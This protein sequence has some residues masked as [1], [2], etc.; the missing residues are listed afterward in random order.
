MK[1]FSVWKNAKSQNAAKAAGIEV[2]ELKRLVDTYGGRK[3]WK[4]YDKVVE[5]NL[6]LK[7]HRDIRDLIENRT[8]AQTKTPEE[9]KA[10]WIKR[11]AKL[12]G[13]SEEEAARIAQI[14]EDA[15]ASGIELLEK[16]QLERF[17]RKRQ[18]L[19]DKLRRQNPLR[20]IKDKD[21]AANILIA[22]RRHAATDYDYRLEEARYLAEKGEIE[23]DEVK[24]YARKNRRDRLPPLA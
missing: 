15:H 18:Q 14:K 7:A 17:S 12:T 22:N 8:P 3:A 5:L 19:I 9:K 23:R 20:I 4:V 16:R 1:I 10:A 13:V 11:L 21:H 6:R 24:E 2:K